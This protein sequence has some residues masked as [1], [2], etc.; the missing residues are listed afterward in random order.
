MVDF[1][2]GVL[3]FCLTACR[4]AL[5]SFL[6]IIRG[7]LQWSLSFIVGLCALNVV[8]FILFMRGDPI[9]WEVV[10]SCLGGAIGAN[11]LIFAFDWLI[12]KV[13]PQGDLYLAS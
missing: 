9:F 2:I 7:V 6:M 4:Y 12:L 13:N 3:V 11:L 5:F 10:L 1:I 8:V